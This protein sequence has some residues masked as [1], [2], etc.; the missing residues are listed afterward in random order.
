MLKISY[1]RKLFSLTQ[2]GE[3]TQNS[4]IERFNRAFR[5]EVLDSFF[6]KVLKKTRALTKPGCGFTIM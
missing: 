6:L 3:P 4:L 2:S 1:L 5:E